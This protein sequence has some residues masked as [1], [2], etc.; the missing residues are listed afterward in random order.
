MTTAIVRSGRS[1]SNG[2]C[3]LRL[4]NGFPGNVGSAA[5]WKSLLSDG[6]YP[7]PAVELSTQQL[8]PPLLPSQPLLRGHPFRGSQ[9]Q[10]LA[11]SGNTMYQQERNAGS[12]NNQGATNN[13]RSKVYRDGPGLGSASTVQSN[14][15]TQTA[16]TNPVTTT[17][18]VDSPSTTNDYTGSGNGLYGLTGSGLGVPGGVRGLP[19][20]VAE[21]VLPF[22]GGALNGVLRHDAS[23]VYHIRPSRTVDPCFVAAMAGLPRLVPAH[24]AE[25]VVR[26]Y[27]DCLRMADYLTHSRGRG[28]AVREH[29]RS[30]FRK[31]MHETDPAKIAELKESATRAL[32]NYMVYEAGNLARRGKI[33]RPR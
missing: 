2:I 32:T 33:L 22:A 4:A 21:T 20:A 26:L 25:N 5:L 13:Q 15:Q 19:L 12:I 17:V 6:L 1:R 27:R 8:L 31:H 3:P 10:V 24:V 16:D 11:G 18:S 23:P 30:E 9:K 28:P 29:I 14:Q 7:M